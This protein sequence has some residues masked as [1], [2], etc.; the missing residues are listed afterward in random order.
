MSPGRTPVLGLLVFSFWPLVSVVSAHLKFPSC[1]CHP[2]CSLL[3]APALI[4]TVISPALS[5]APSSCSNFSSLLPVLSSFLPPWPALSCPPSLSCSSISQQ[6]LHLRFGCH[7]CALPSDKS[8]QSHRVRSG[9]NTS[10]NHKMKRRLSY[11]L[12][13]PNLN[14]TSPKYFLSSHF[15]WILLSSS[16]N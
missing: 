5:S 3:L 1:A 9:G 8:S 6:N 16:V 12:L 10:Q 14:P 11:H 13:T 15:L 7:I 4:S 2:L